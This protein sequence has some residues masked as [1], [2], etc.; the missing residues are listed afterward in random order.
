M[1]RVNVDLRLILIVLLLFF[2]GGYY[3]V[4]DFTKEPV[5]PVVVIIPEKTGE[6]RKVI[7][8]VPTD[9]VYI[10]KYLPGKSQ[11]IITEVVVDST[12]KEA[13]EEALKQ[14]D[15]LRAKNLFLESISINKWE[16]TLIDNEDVKIDG[17]FTTRCELLEYN[18]DY[19]IKES[20][21]TYVPEMVTKLPKLS[22]VG[23]I[24]IS[25][26][27][28]PGTGVVPLIGAHIGIRTGKGITYSLGLDSQE[29]V[30]VGIE[31]TILKTKR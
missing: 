20:S 7:N 11:E 3:I 23:G 21:L 6:E 30:S 25:T 29:R 15:T 19:K 5:D 8:S 31:L 16:G 10:T 9:T 2:A 1:M 18:V 12:Y 4:K 27:R 17:E 24:T 14:N 28:S 22:L 13:Y 26:P